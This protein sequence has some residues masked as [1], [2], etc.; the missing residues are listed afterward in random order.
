MKPSI[1]DLLKASNDLSAQA[2]TTWIAFILFGAYLVVAVGGTTHRQL[3]L[4]NS[5]ELPVLGAKLPLVAFYQVVPP[6]FVFVHF[7]VLLQI[8][9]LSRTLHLVNAR[10]DKEVRLASE[11]LQ[12]RA[13]VDGFAIT[14]FLGN[15]NSD[16]LTQLSLWLVVW[17]TL[18]VAP[19]ALLLNCQ[20]HFLPY[21]DPAT[22]W[23]H[24][25][26]LMADLL[27]I[28]AIWPAVVKPR[29][30]F[31]GTY[32]AWV[33]R[34]L[35]EMRHATFVETRVAKPLIKYNWRSAFLKL[36][37][38]L[39]TISPKDAIWTFGCAVKIAALTAACVGV[40]GFSLLIATVPDEG[41]DQWLTARMNNLPS[42]DL[43]RTCF[44]EE[45]WPKT[46]CLL[47]RRI[48]VSRFQRPHGAGV[49]VGMVWWPTMILSE[50]APY[51][52]VWFRRD[53]IVVYTNLIGLDD[54]QLKRVQYSISLRR[55]DL[56]GSVLDGVDLRKADMR[57]VNL[58]GARLD[59]AELQGADFSSADLQSASLSRA[60]LQN[61]KLSFA[62]LQ[63]GDLSEA[64]LQ[65][66]DLTGT[67]LEG[68]NLLN[69]QGADL[70]KAELQNLEPR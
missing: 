54:E 52:S 39:R 70:S 41:I 44:D 66:A 14:Q 11:R 33:R 27:L 17:G 30:Q 36:R 12:W 69:V 22:T 25:I 19:I 20:V 57:E 28:A 5:I 24:R 60:Q 10:L 68:T 51:K 64:Q 32:V 56:R 38:Y 67:H 59:S 37:R 21:H 61:A 35:V 55:R 15:S 8:F 34:L 40:L 16:W 29:Q 45:G 7:Y 62:R 1:E 3:L 2:R 42:N 6:L 53:L 63:G 13:R 9:L 46:G 48:W 31:G 26:C 50:S 49:D 65:G 47:E 58:Q 43:P 18:L 23:I 4:E